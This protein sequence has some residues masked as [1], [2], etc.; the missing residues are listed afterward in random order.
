VAHRFQ[1]WPL[2]KLEAKADQMIS[3]RAGTLWAG[4][5]GTALFLA[6]WL[7]IR[8]ISTFSVT[9]WV[10]MMS[11]GAVMCFYG[12]VRRSKWFLLPAFAAVLVIAG[13]FA[14]V[15]RGG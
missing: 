2:V 5:G 7:M 3:Q 9:L 11:L 1:R 6:S 4:W 12:G 14:A 10:G 8:R 13:V 15:Y